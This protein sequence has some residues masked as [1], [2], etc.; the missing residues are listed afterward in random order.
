MNALPVV[1][2]PAANIL[3]E[4]QTQYGSSGHCA[5]LAF[6]PDSDIRYEVE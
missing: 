4:T 3:V 1:R 5:M 6:L 2:V